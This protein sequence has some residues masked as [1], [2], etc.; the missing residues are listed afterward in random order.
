MIVNG[1][2]ARRGLALERCMA[3]IELFLKTSYSTD[4]T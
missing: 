1:L 4:L 3:A 2:A